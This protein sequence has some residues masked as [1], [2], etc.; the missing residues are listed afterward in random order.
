MHTAVK[1]LVLVLLLYT[2]Y[3][4]VLQNVP[5]SVKRCGPRYKGY[6]NELQ[7]ERNKGQKA[8]RF[9]LQHKVLPRRCAHLDESSRGCFNCR[10]T[11]ALGRNTSKRGGQAF[12]MPEPGFGSNSDSATNAS[13]YANQRTRIERREEERLHPDHVN[14][15]ELSRHGDIGIKPAGGAISFPSSRRTR[16]NYKRARSVNP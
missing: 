4:Y 2:W 1:V 8:K 9:G 5:G 16:A 14:P 12:L 13:A 11:N 15:R 10:Q 6:N 7:F 3:I